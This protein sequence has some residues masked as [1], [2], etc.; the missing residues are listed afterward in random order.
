MNMN[1]SGNRSPAF[2]CLVKFLNA[3]LKLRNFRLLPTFWFVF[4]EMSLAF[5]LPV[6]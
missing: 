5:A 6:S 4:F 2:P 1:H 3:K